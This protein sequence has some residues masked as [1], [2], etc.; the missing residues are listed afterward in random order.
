MAEDL[1]QSIDTLNNSIN[2][3]IKIFKDASEQLKVDEHDSKIVDKKISPIMKKIS[4]LEEQ[5]E[6]IAR[7]IVAVADML[8]ERQQIMPRQKMPEFKPQQPLIR[9]SASSGPSSGFSGANKSS[10]NYQPRPQPNQT[11]AQNQNFGQKSPTPQVKPLP[12]SEP[13]KQDKKGFLD[14]FKK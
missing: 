13:E 1:K 9:P 2:S 14:M 4:M 11:N 3:L 6:K 8:K 7:G 12:R 10:Q 5:N